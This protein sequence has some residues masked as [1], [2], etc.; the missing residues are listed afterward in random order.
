MNNKHGVGDIIA[1]K[2]YELVNKGLPKEQI[3]PKVKKLSKNLGINIEE[4]DIIAIVEHAMDAIKTNAFHAGVQAF[5][6]ETEKADRH[7]YVG[8]DGKSYHTRADL[9]IANSVH[10]NGKINKF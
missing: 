2:I 5:L 8:R 7:A 9:D 3:I 1:D 6:S 10:Q 4:E